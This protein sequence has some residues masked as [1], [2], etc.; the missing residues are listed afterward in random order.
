MVLYEGLRVD[1][2]SG[3][4]DDVNVYLNPNLRQLQPGYDLSEIDDDQ[5]LEQIKKC[6]QGAI[7]GSSVGTGKGFESVFWDSTV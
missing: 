6:R 1:F 5:E 3:L 7:G 2:I 4:C